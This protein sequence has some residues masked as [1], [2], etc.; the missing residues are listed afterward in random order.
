VYV[1]DWVTQM[2]AKQRR[3]N[4]GQPIAGSVLS[5]KFIKN[6]KAVLSQCFDFAIE[7]RPVPIEVNPA[8]GIRLPRQDRREM[9]FLQDEQAYLELRCRMHA[10]FQ[11]VLDFLVGTGA[12][13][14][15]AAGLLV[16][17][18]APERGAAVRGHPP[19]A[20]VGREEVE[21]EPAQDPVPGAPDHPLP[22]ARAD[23]AAARRG[24]RGRCVRVHDS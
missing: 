12:R 5:I 3:N 7:Q 15:E 10:H 21:A 17:Q 11:P 18:S 8:R 22:Q 16:P 2:L 19:G 6:V 14:G 24:Q 13:Y 9:H 1:D 23:P 4:V 20:E